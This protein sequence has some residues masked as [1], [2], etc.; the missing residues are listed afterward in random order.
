LVVIAII[1]IL[2]ALLLPAVQAARESARRMQCAN[3]LKQLSLGL[4][5]YESQNKKLPQATAYGFRHGST[6]VAAILPFIEETSIYDLFDFKKPM[7]DPANDIAVKALIPTLVCPSD[8]QSSEPILKKRGQSPAF[9]GGIWNPSESHGL[10]YPV[11]IGPTHPDACPFCP[12]STPSGTNWC[13][14]GC[15]F[16][17]Y[18]SYCGGSIKDGS[19]TGMFGRHPTN[20]RFTDVSDG[21]SNTIMM[22]ETL[23]YHYIWNGA[24]CPNYPVVSTS[25]PLNTFESDNGEWSNWWRASS[26]KSMH[27]GG[28][29]LALGD[30]SVHFVS[31]TI[32]HRLY[33]GLSTRAGGEA[34]KLP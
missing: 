9:P 14:Q 23:P 19:F 20:V 7:F 5:N 28:A 24:Y 1:A 34:Y 25:I 12:D 3:H 10:W 29:Q 11:C 8:G 31:E 22:G 30:G 15:N 6:W 18:G 16:G 27:P 32:D 2:I 21:L 33:A 26:Y 4:H 17:T 13:C